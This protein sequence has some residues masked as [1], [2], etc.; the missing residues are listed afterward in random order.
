M[1]KKTCQPSEATIR[2]KKRNDETLRRTIKREE[3]KIE[4]AKRRLENEIKILKDQ[5]DAG[6]KNV[7]NTFKEMD[8]AAKKSD[9]NMQAGEIAREKAKQESRIKAFENIESRGEFERVIALTPDG[10]GV[11]GTNFAQSPDHA[12]QYPREKDSPPDSA[13]LAVELVEA[14]TGEKGEKALE[15]WVN[16]EK[17]EF[18]KGGELD[19]SDFVEI[20]KKIVAKKYPKKTFEHQHLQA[21]AGLKLFLRL[22]SVRAESLRVF[23]NKT[24]TLISTVNLDEDFNR[25]NLIEDI[26]SLNA[27][28]DVLLGTAKE[29]IGHPYTFEGMIE[30]S[31]GLVNSVSALF[32]RDGKRLKDP[33]HELHSGV[34]SVTY[35]DFET[36]ARKEV[37]VPQQDDGISSALIINDV[38]AFAADVGLAS[39]VVTDNR[40]SRGVDP[41]T[42]RKVQFRSAFVKNHQA[43]VSMS[44]EPARILHEVGHAIWYY[45]RQRGFDLSK[46]L[47]TSDD[48]ASAISFVGSH[49][50][51]HKGLS[52]DEHAGEMEIKPWLKDFLA[53]DDVSTNS[54]REGFP[55]F[56][57]LWFWNRQEAFNRAP[58]LTKKWEKMLRSLPAEIREKINLLQ[59]K[60]HVFYLQSYDVLNET[61]YSDQGQQTDFGYLTKRERGRAQYLAEK[62]AEK[63]EKSAS[64][65][66]SWETAWVSSGFQILHWNLFFL[67]ESKG[68]LNSSQ[69]ELLLKTNAALNIID[70]MLQRGSEVVLHEN[71]V[72]PTFRGIPLNKIFEEL[73]GRKEQRRFLIWMAAKN[74]KER[75]VRAK[76]LGISFDSTGSPRTLGEIEH[77]I[78]N[79]DKGVMFDGRSREGVYRETEQ[80]ILSTSKS[81]LNY[82][83]H[84][85]AMTQEE[86]DNLITQNPHWT[87]TYRQ[88]DDVQTE[89]HSAMHKKGSARNYQ[90]PKLSYVKGLRTMLQRNMKKAAISHLA[91]MVIES[92][93]P[94][95][96]NYGIITYPEWRGTKSSAAQSKKMREDVKNSVLEEMKANGEDHQ[97]IV[98][99]YLD[100]AMEKTG[101]LLTIWDKANPEPASDKVMVDAVSKDG[102]R[103][104]IEIS[105]P[106]LRELITRLRAPIPKPGGFANFFA[107]FA[108]AFSLFSTSIIVPGFV[109]MDTP[110]TSYQIW[111]DLGRVGMNKANLAKL[112]GINAIYGFQSWVQKHYVFRQ[113]RQKILEGKKLTP[114]E[115]HWVRVYYAMGQMNL[116]SDAGTLTAHHIP[117]DTM[118]IMEL[119]AELAKPGITA[120]RKAWVYAKLTSFLLLHGIGIMSSFTDNIM[121]TGLLN[122]AV[123]DLNLPF[124]Q[125]L[126]NAQMALGRLDLPGTDPLANAIKRALPFSNP[127]IAGRWGSRMRTT[128][129]IISGRDKGSY[130]KRSRADAAAALTSGLGMMYMIAAAWILLDFWDWD[131]DFEE[132]IEDFLV[133]QS[134]RSSSFRTTGMILRDREGKESRVPLPHDTGPFIYSQAFEA[135]LLLLSRSFK[136]THKEIRRQ[137]LDF[138]G[139][140]LIEASLLTL[141]PNP[142]ASF[143][144]GWLS[145][146][147]LT[148]RKVGD[149]ANVDAFDSYTKE[150]PTTKES[151]KRLAARLGSG[152]LTASLIDWFLR[153]HGGSFYENIDRL[154][155]WSLWDKEEKGERPGEGIWAELLLRGLRPGRKQS[156]LKMGGELKNRVYEA[157]EIVKRSVAELRTWIANENHESET[158][159]KN[160]RELLKHNW[161]Q[162]GDYNPGRGISQL[163]RKL[164][165]M[166]EQIR[167]TI[168]AVREDPELTLEMKEEWLSVIGQRAYRFELGEGGTGWNQEEG[169]SLQRV[170]DLIVESFETMLINKDV[171][172]DKPQPLSVIG[173]AQERDMSSIIVD[174]KFDATAGMPKEFVERFEDYTY[175]DINGDRQRLNQI[176]DNGYLFFKNSFLKTLKD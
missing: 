153:S 131:K 74:D 8:R 173:T 111:V 15:A 128:W 136:D 150:E 56:V 80:K 26:T 61:H 41:G 167:H 45:G 135:T 27:K 78:M 62:F 157:S 119:K 83:V 3:A 49:P 69:I 99:E 71:S 149:A 115:M 176:Y 7:E 14:V 107:G 76:K 68:R 33:T 161:G 79:G 24:A 151:A 64:R 90:D 72:N 43:V 117:I 137:Y 172:L 5:E 20:Y 129:L 138:L 147:D 112:P 39:I 169:T 170:M 141:P 6:V 22:R 40:T 108:G 164:K 63:V 132:N 21:M 124:D 77:Q 81:L 13:Q 139:K 75:L 66:R 97:D 96:G 60:T 130:V 144:I 65:Y 156:A 123:V 125:V 19:T 146:Y 59:E 38:R 4:L 113:A 47:E 142:A 103:I 51:Y 121:K 162:D 53:E 82:S 12:R 118:S 106:E 101:D 18:F 54:L 133:A 91:L 155:E 104:F 35:T 116:L 98:A 46:V 120:K 89:G 23:L 94:S 154:F 44:W 42:A 126:R 174:V 163:V 32:K 29:I 143:L 70:H 171:N 93:L 85:G 36:G 48:I 57:E 166:D 16:L 152:E 30:V 175:I 95:R 28:R 105:N 165:T 31:E 102:N 73:G 50:E 52:E 86:M 160:A 1:S 168:K 127:T 100:R 148:G 87:A 84:I 110:R 114:E 17:A 159:V 10:T 25:K 140:T 37:K 55:R 34:K 109:I 88:T 158:K 145:G 67:G 134:Q 58:G 122:P 92:N 9:K 11:I 2:A